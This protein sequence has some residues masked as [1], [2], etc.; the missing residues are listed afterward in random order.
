MKSSKEC[1]GEFA[2]LVYNQTL[3]QRSKQ[4]YRCFDNGIRGGSARLR[5]CILSCQ[6]LNGV[7]FIT[8]K[9]RYIITN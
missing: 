3:L 4:V 9:K 7:S 5:L 1:L 6:F 2:L 8:T